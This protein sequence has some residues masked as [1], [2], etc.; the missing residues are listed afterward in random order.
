MN[1][2]EIAVKLSKLSLKYKEVPVG[3]VIVSEDKIISGAFNSMETDKSSLSHAELKAI[4]SAQKKLDKWRLNDCEL[5][6]TLEPCVMCTGA[7]YLSRIKKVHFIVGASE[8]GLSDFPYNI[9]IIR[10]ENEEYKN[11]LKDF[12]K[13]LRKRI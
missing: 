8:L 3:A 2:M 4:K 1:P 12:F 7:I 10:E 9:E 11:L 13:N 6:V 5:Y